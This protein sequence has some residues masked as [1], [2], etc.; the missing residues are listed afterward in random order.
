MLINDQGE[1]VI[2]VINDYARSWSLLQGFD[3]QSL[4][5][6]TSKQP[7]MLPLNL[8]DVLKA[9]GQLKQELIRKGEAT[10]PFGQTRTAGLVS[11][12]GIIKQGFGDEWFYP[13]VASR[14]AIL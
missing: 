2:G 9:I 14:A 8:D 11:T 6:Q 10:E 4:K 12:I 3:E 1:A 13:N 7:D 5:E